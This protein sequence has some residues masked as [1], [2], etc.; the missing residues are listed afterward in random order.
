MDEEEGRSD[1]KDGKDGKD[2]KDEVRKRERES[3]R[4]GVD[5][6]RERERDDGGWSNSVLSTHSF[7]SK[8]KIL[9][10]WQL[11]FLLSKARPGY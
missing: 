1:E 9:F 2:E 8:L 3:G 6:E 5:G 4:E 10:F 11:F 7:N